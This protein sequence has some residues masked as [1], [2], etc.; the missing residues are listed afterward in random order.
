MDKESILIIGGG[1]AGLMAAKELS[2]K[3]HVTILE[4]QERLGGRIHTLEAY[5]GAAIEAGAEFVH[6]PLPI[7]LQLLDKANIEYK[8]ISG[9]M[10]RIENGDWK[11][12]EEMIEGW[13]DMIKK[14]L[15]SK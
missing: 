8:P 7:T 11:E 6:G 4:A 5:H 13:N 14:W 2:I 9:R 1:A 12:E 3:Y 10:Y 15:Q